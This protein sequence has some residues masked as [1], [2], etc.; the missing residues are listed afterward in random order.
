MDPDPGGP[1]TCGS[2]GSGSPTLLFLALTFSFVLFVGPPEACESSYN[3]T[4]RVTGLTNLGKQ[5]I[6]FGKYCRVSMQYFNVNTKKDDQR[7]YANPVL[8]DIAFILIHTLD[9]S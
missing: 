8:V 1:K 4:F 6:S 2:S 5:H 7:Q 3:L 9:Y